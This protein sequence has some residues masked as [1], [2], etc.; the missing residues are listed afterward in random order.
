[1]ARQSRSVLIG[2]C[3]LLNGG[4]DDDD[5]IRSMS[6][7]S[8]PPL[9]PAL[10]LR[11]QDPIERRSPSGPKSIKK[12][13]KRFSFRTLLLLMT[14]LAALATCDPGRLSPSLLWKRLGLNRAIGGPQISSMKK[15]GQST[16]YF[17]KLP[18]QP[19]YYIPSNYF[20][21]EPSRDDPA[22]P[23]EKVSVTDPKKRKK[24]SFFL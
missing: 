20:A 4:H 10:V 1:M 12:N 9:R 11:D 6:L 8:P 19:H 2:R 22:D 18:P 17:I 14:T 3:F 21:P 7:A 23:F 24:D 16:V 13:N 15:T 5:F